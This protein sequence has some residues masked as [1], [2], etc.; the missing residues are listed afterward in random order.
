MSGPKL[1]GLGGACKSK[2]K[3]H[4]KVIL[5]SSQRWH[6]EI[7]MGIE[8]NKCSGNANIAIDAME[9]LKARAGFGINLSRT[10]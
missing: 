4:E 6:I 9:I 8:Y 3:A 5:E 10:L 1:I 7:W 2:K